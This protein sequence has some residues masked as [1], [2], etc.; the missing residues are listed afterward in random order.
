MTKIRTAGG[1]VLEVDDDATIE[2][3]TSGQVPV[4]VVRGQIVVGYSG[5]PIK[6]V[7]DCGQEMIVSMGDPI[8]KGPG[9]RIW[10]D[11]DEAHRLIARGIVKPAGDER[12][13]LAPAG[14]AT[15]P[16]NGV[17]VET[18]DGLKI[19]AAA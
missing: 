8:M 3:G 9:E 1:N 5:T 10:L 7:N 14:A 13:A 2:S 12:D 17:N 19:T 18:N 11:A 15:G 6:G 16:T 4:V